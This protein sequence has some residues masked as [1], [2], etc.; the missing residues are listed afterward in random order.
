VTDALFSSRSSF[1]PPFGFSTYAAPLIPGRDDLNRANLMGAFGTLLGAT[2]VA[3]PALLPGA[4][5]RLAPLVPSAGILANRLMSLQAPIVKNP[6][7]QSAVSKLF[8]TTDRYPGGTAGAIRVTALTGRLVGGSKH[9]QAGIDRAN[10]LRN[11]L[12]AETLSA[13]DRAAAL[14]LRN[15]LIGALRLAGIDY[16]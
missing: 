16:P 14:A 11:I 12:S 7:L 15:D 10:N 5:I 2:A 8:Q 6:N 4:L 9:I 3:T 13:S 1:L